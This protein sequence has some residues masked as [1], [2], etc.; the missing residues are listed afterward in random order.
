MKQ[1]PILYLTIILP[2]F[3]RSSGIVPAF[4]RDGAEGPQI[5]ATSATPAGVGSL[6]FA[7]PGVSP[8]SPAAQLAQPPANVCDPYRDRRTARHQNLL[9]A[10]I[11]QTT[12]VSRGIGSVASR[13]P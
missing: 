6:R 10:E 8:A 12:H 3:Q 11:S 2:K 4:Q 7:R 5:V 9:R 13:M 1:R